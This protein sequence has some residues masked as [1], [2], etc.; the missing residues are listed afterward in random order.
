MDGQRR[1][2]ENNGRQRAGEVD[3]DAGTTA[4]T[5]GIYTPNRI[6]AA[7][8]TAHMAATAYIT[9]TIVGHQ[10]QRRKTI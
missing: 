6:P 2:G 5:G 4:W 7:A 9:I 8:A 3:A 10:V 1:G